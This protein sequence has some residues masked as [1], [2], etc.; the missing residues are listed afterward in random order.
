MDEDI[1]K[2]LEENIEISEESLKILKGIRRANRIAAAFKIFYWLI[3]IGSVVGAY[4]YLQPYI[5][6]I[7]N[8]PPDILKSLQE[9]MKPK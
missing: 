3:I 8:L 6:Q 2:L 5:E 1:K 4:Y 9:I 7:K